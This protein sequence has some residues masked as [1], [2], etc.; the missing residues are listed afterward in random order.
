MR[1]IQ[2]TQVDALGPETIVV[3]AREE[4]SYLSGHI[5]RAINLPA[6]DQWTPSGRL[7]PIGQIAA[8]YAQRGLLSGGDVVVYCGGGVLSALEVLTLQACGVAPSLYVGSWSE[9]C[10]S[11]QRMQRSAEQRRVA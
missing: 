11:P 5:P 6:S 7:R 2:A 3:D 1:S 9:W 8:A 10:K 4:A